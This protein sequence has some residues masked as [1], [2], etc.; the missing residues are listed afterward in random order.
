[1]NKAEFD[2]AVDRA[3]D[4]LPTW[5]M[6]RVDNLHVVVEEWPTEEQVTSWASVTAF[7]CWSAHPTTGAP[8]RT[9]SSSSVSLISSWDS[10]MKTSKKR[11]GGPCSTNWPTTSASTTAGSRSSA[12]I[13][14]ERRLVAG[15]PALLSTSAG[16]PNC[17]HV[18]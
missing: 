2:A 4:G 10:A 7:R 15:I 9:E 8:C 18:P 14:Y 5:V 13:D 12:G 1:M 3:L 11:Y 17:R 16:T 6:E